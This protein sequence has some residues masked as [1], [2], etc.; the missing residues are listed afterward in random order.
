MQQEDPASKI[1]DV[2]LGGDHTLVLSTNNR[3]VYAFGKGGDGQLGFVGK[4][5][6][7]APKKSKILSQ[8]GTAAVCAIQNC[9]LTLDQ[10]G[11]IKRKVGKRCNSDE[12]R[13]GI[14]K[15]L[16]RARRHGLITDTRREA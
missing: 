5:F 3:D 9:S 4:P 16:A 14:V 6:V 12:V 2:S 7:S 13:D 1:H 11:E 10:D 8:P 15:C